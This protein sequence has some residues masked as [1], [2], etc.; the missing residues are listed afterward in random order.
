MT[1]HIDQEEFKKLATD[2]KVG[3]SKAFEKASEATR[4]GVKSAAPHVMH[5][6]DTTVKTA[7]P[8][9]DSAADTAAKLTA[10]AGE[11]LDTF[12]EDMVNEYLPRITSAVEEAAAK[13]KAEADRAAGLVAETTVAPI[14]VA[15]TKRKRSGRAGKVFRW[16]LLAGAAAGAGYLVWRRS[17]PVE[18]PWAEEYWADLET[19]VPVEEVTPEQVAD[20]E[21]VA[22]AEQIVEE[23]AEEDN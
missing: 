17:Q 2:I 23:A 1:T 10:K 22:D 12:H 15:T 7:S 6:V 8:Y 19:D 21:V 20:A 16:S 3:A 5:A 11:A 18:D 13:A 4:S 14:E 9:V